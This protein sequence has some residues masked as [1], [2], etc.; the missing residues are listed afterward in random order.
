LWRRWKPAWSREICNRR[1][2]RRDFFI[3]PTRRRWAFS[4]LG[5]N[6]AANAGGPRCLKYGVTRHYV[7]GL[8]VVLADGTILN[9][10]G[11]THKNK[12]GFDLLGLMVGSE[13]M[14][15]VVTA[16]TLRLLPHPP[17]RAGLAAIFPG[18]RK[19]CIRCRSY[20]R[21]RTFTRRL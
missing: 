16:A 8:E 7:L 19:R 10:G 18:H 9:L 21:R 20:L 1:L 3:R 17:F 11:R 14:L 5:G 15:G 2:E 4:T 13:G 12:T 6:I